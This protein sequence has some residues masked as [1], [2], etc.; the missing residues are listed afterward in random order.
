MW[1]DFRTDEDSSMTAGV[2]KIT[3]G[4]G[5][6]IR[7]YV[8]RPEGPGP[9]PG[10][11]L[12]HHVLGWDEYHRE[13][14]R[15]FAENGYI[16]IVPNLFE[17]FGHGTPDEVAAKV[18]ADGGVSD[19]SVVADA[20]AALAWAKAQPGSNG[21]VGVIGPCSG[22]RHALLVASSTDGFDAVAN[23]WGGGVTTTP[24]PPNPNQPVAVIDLIPN[25]KAPVIGIFGNDDMNPNPAAVDQL[26][27]ALK[28]N[29]KT[30]A[31]HRYDGAG[32]GFFYYQ[33]QAY[34]PQQAMDA[35]GKV[36]TFFNQY[37]N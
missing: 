24:N 27:A 33:G 6:Q 13:F 25:L 36:L 35:W 29:G 1:N 17:R 11:V 9:Y 26:E 28:A 2:I 31:F 21:K 15:R 12:M 30:Y 16:A 20:A 4:G 18:R 32:H 5:D 19:A 37:L 10:V 8:A 23:L 14:A 3:G 22:G 7:A 34:R